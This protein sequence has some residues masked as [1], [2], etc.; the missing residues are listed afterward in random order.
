[1]ASFIFQMLQNSL[2]EEKTVENHDSG[3]PDLEMN[4]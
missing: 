1:M 2:F 3:M 4:A